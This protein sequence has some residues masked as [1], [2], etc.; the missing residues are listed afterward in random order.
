M[1]KRQPLRFTHQRHTRTAWPIS[2][3]TWHFDKAN[4]A[5]QLMSEPYKLNQW[6]TTTVCILG[7]SSP[8]MNTAEAHASRTTLCRSPPLSQ[9]TVSQG[10]RYNCALIVNWV[11]WQANKQHRF[12]RS[13]WLILDSLSISQYVYRLEKTVGQRRC[14]LWYYVLLFLFYFKPALYKKLGFGCWWTKINLPY[15]TQRFSPKR[16]RKLML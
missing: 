12:W 4:E 6:G 15:W 16:T 8:L 2:I 5:Q 9:A 1:L 13:I 10:T 3:D 7:T 14:S 11:L